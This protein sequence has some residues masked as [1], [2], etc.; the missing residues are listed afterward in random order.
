MIIIKKSDYP[1]LIDNPNGESIQEL[2]GIQAGGAQ[3]HSLAMVTIQPGKGSEPHFH[4]KSDE[5]YLILSGRASMQINNEHFE[6][7]V[8]EAVLIEPMDIHQITNHS[9]ENLVFLAA[10]VPAWQPDDSFEAA[11]SDKK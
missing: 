4:K 11:F 3:S 5:S 10:C 1:A 8:G 7:G 6:L 9:D 2:L